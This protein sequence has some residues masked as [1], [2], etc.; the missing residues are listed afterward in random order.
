MK[1]ASYL[2]HLRFDKKLSE[3]VQAKYLRNPRLLVL[4]LIIIFSLGIF[5]YQNLPRRL[6]PEIKIPLVIV[7]TVLPGASPTDVESLVTDPIE[8]S[9][10]SVQNIKTYSSTSRDSVSVI[11]IEFN[12]GTDADKAT[13]D[14]KSAVDSVDLPEEAQKT[15]VSKIDFERFPVWSFSLVSKNDDTASLITFS[16][17]LEE[18]LKNVG[19]VDE[20]TV[21]G[22]E[23]QEIQILLKPEQISTYQINPQVIF[24]AIRNATKSVPAGTV[25]TDDSSFTL[26]IDPTI[27]NIDDIRNIKINN[28]GT[29]INLSD[30]A[31]VSIKSKPSQLQSFVA[32]ENLGARQAVSFSIYKTEN[33]DISKTVEETNKELESTLKQY[34]NQFAVF[35]T[36][37]VSDEIDEQFSGLIRDFLITISMVFLAL[38]IFLG[39]RQAIVASLSIPITFLITFSVMNL[40]G[41]SLSFISF[42]SLLLALGL[43]VDDTIVVISAMTSYYR[44]GKFTPYETGLLVWKDFIVAIFTTTLTTVWAFL[45]LLMSSGIIGEFIKPIPIVVST[46]LLAS[47]FVAMFITLPIITY[48]LKPAMPR[49]VKGLLIAL[50]VLGII[51]ILFAVSGKTPLVILEIGVLAILLFVLFRT[52]DV[53]K[54]KL[55]TQKYVKP[56]TV[57][58]YLDEGFLSFEPLSIR[59]QLFIRKI[60]A[61]KRNMRLVIVF[62]I[63]FSVFSYMLVPFGFVKN[64]FFPKTDSK[65]LNISVE[66][67]VG[68]NISTTKMEGLRILEKLKHTKNIDTVTLNMGQTTGDFGAGQG[69]VN[70]ILYTLVLAE[71]K[72]QSSDEIA[73]GLRSEFKDYN[74]GNFQVLEPSNG[75]PAGAD[76]QLK[77]IGPDLGVLDQYATE[78]M[79]YLESQPGV[80][81]VD[82]SIKP[83]TSKVTFKPDPQKLSEAG[84]AL[85]QVALSLRT[86]ASG[87][88]LDSVKFDASSNDEQDITL[89][90]SDSEQFIESIDTLLI[91]TQTGESVPLQSLGSLELQASPALITREDGDRTLSVTA[92]VTAGGNIQTINKELETYA[93][94]LDLPTGYSWKTGGVNEENQNSVNT[95]LIAMVLSFLLILVTMVLQFSSFR[96]AF[97]VLLVIPL[98]ISG[99][100][101]IFALTNTPLSFPALIGVLA[102]FGIVVKNAILIVDKIQANENQPHMSLEEGVAEGSASRLEAIALTSFTAIL[103][104]IPVTISDPLWRGLGGAIIAGLTFSGTIMLFFIPVVYYLTFKPS[105]KRKK[106]SR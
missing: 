2:K 32:E 47:F 61:S 9:L 68:T 63:I 97:I 65:E 52:R 8:D 31:S 80:T 10:G 54:N 27:T 78:V 36:S 82:K 56:K 7:S 35:T 99:V 29:I 20:V 100:F 71:D 15:N 98:S 67:P 41:V 14:V 96:K 84:V 46:T 91:P 72:D 88:E 69:D 25:R 86:F 24:A 74:K 1:H 3:S 104:L 23:E 66:L 89:R 38:L 4:L 50:V 85:D 43:L 105:G 13:S 57:R 73:Q 17:T 106:A 101:I 76:I 11:Q 26:S 102:L 103:G 12:T 53:L 58:K 95:I 79:S 93:D 62:V 21:S 64:E 90:F 55:L 39:I 30:V 33:A 45:P 83:G 92:S 28:Q 59:Y 87:F 18:R 70:N 22:L 60:L 40:F 19:L 48:F 16:K 6:N 49:R 34:D 37:D 75:P 51:G 42:F 81:N 5:S 44:S 94:S 77:L